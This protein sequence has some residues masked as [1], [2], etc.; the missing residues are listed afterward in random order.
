M[1]SLQA[2]YTRDDNMVFR[3]IGEEMILVPIR[4]RTAD[5]ESIYTLND[6][7]AFIW[8]QLDGQ[9]TLAEVR[10][11][12]VAEYEVTPEEA[13]ADVLEFVTNLVEAQGVRAVA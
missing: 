3:R 9:R 12:L 4:R 7:G 13:E 5:L 6:T 11:A 10:D 2:V 1:V 8:E